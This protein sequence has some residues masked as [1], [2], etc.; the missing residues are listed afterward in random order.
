MITR[1]DKHRLSGLFTA[2]AA[3]FV[4]V[5]GLC[6]QSFAAAAPAPKGKAPQQQ[7][8]AQPN[9]AEEIPLQY[10][11]VAIEALVV[12]INE[13]YTRQVGLQ[14]TYGR[15][16][17]EPSIVKG[18]DFNAPNQPP[19]VIVPQMNVIPGGFQFNNVTRSAGVG[20]S[21]TEMDVSDGKVGMRLRALIEEG[22]A[23]I[24]SRPLAVTL[25][26]NPVK[27]ETVDKVPYQDV[28]FKGASGKITIQF[29]PVGVI[30]N[31]TPRIKS[32][33]EGLV[34]LDLTK[35]EVS[36]VGRF[37]NINNVQRPV[38]VKSEA[39]TKVILRNHETLVIGG[40][41][42][43]NMAKSSQGIP[44]LRRIPI[45]KYLFSNETKNL[46]RRDILFYIT[47]HI[48]PPGV[49]PTLPPRFIHNSE[50]N[51]ILQIPPPEQP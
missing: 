5:G 43:E 35:L 7:A 47:P 46:E 27:I 44:F 38:F 32:L 18:I 10:Y 22:K 3:V 30:L 15:N 12:E 49:Q 34:E 33:K 8:A 9:A 50:L 1:A 19:G 40:F 2:T 11:Q 21:L 26:G 29:E 13:K 31:V 48:L 36:A 45:I 41:K 20:L 4:L 14:Y 25:N 51:N 17:G 6:F 24:R 37:V 42:I 23:R 39:D 28:V 16:T